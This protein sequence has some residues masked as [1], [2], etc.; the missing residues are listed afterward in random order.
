M[1]RNTQA[2]INVINGQVLLPSNVELRDLTVFGGQHSLTISG[3]LHVAVNLRLA[4]FRKFPM[5]S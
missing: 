1:I 3:A 4:E 5:I 2:Y